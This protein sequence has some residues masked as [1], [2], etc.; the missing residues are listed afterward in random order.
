MAQARHAFNEGWNYDDIHKLTHPL[1]I[2]MGGKK[3][4]SSIPEPATIPKSN[5]IQRQ[6][7]LN[8]TALV[9]KIAQII[10]SVLS[11]SSPHTS[12]S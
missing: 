1:S 3:A 9:W 7:S 12:Y 5:K 4:C 2:H 10:A 6:L 11:K 8:W